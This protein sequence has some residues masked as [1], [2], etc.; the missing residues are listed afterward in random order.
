[1]TVE[2]FPALPSSLTSSRFLVAFPRATVLARE[3]KLRELT[4]SLQLD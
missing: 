4:V 2:A 3:A 1:M